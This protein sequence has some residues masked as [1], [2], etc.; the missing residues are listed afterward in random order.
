MGKP[1]GLQ[2]LRTVNKQLTPKD[3]KGKGKKR[4]A[5]DDCTVLTKDHEISEDVRAFLDIIKNANTELE[6]KVRDDIDAFDATYGSQEFYET[7]MEVAPDEDTAKAIIKN[8]HTRLLE[9]GNVVGY[10][11]KIYKL[12]ENATV[13]PN[14]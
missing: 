6:K 10:F 2:S 11:E 7:I 1:S 5:L 14:E 3:K 13:K 9:V 4:S 12:F 8:L